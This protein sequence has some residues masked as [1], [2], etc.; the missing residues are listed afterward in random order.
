MLKLHQ[1]GAGSAKLASG[2]V[3]V[4]ELQNIQQAEAP[5][6]ELASTIRQR[7]GAAYGQSAYQSFINGLREDAEIEVLNQ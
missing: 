4:I 3:G 6:E 2:N 7:L 5:D 1:L